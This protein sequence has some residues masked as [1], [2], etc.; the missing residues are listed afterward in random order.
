MLRDP[1]GN[2]TLGLWTTDRCRF[3]CTGVHRIEALFDGNFSINHSKLSVVHSSC[4]RIIRVFAINWQ[5]G[6]IINMYKVRVIAKFP[7][8]NEKSVNWGH[9]KNHIC[10]LCLV[11][12]VLTSGCITQ[13]VQVRIIFLQKF[14][15]W[16]HLGKT[17]LAHNLM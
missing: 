16:K 15:Q 13:E 7:K 8:W 3:I 17:Q 4:N 11:G 6:Q 5:C 14:M 12:R 1:K 10:F 2:W 9:F